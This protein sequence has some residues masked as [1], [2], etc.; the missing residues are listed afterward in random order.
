MSVTFTVS[1]LPDHMW[2]WITHCGCPNNITH[3]STEMIDVS[4]RYS[5]LR[6]AGKRNPDIIMFEDEKV[7]LL[8]QIKY[9][10][11]IIHQEITH[12]IKTLY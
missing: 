10:E 1:Y 3:G 5:Q 7:A 2:K 12:D 6:I 9:N 4:T 11:Y 8:F